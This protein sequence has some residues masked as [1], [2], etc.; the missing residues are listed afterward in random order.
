LSKTDVTF[1]VEEITPYRVYAG[2]EN[3]GNAVAGESR[4]FG[5]VNLGNLFNLDQQLN[6]QFTSAKDPQKWI[7][8]SGTYIIPFRWHHYLKVLGSYS[9]VEPEVEALQNLKGKSYYIGARYEIQLMPYKKLSHDFIFGYDFKTTNNFLTYTDN[10]IFNNNIDISQFLIKYL[11]I[12]EDFLGSTS[13]EAYCYLSPGH[14]TKDNKKSSFSLERK[15]A[16]PTYA[17]FVLDIE[18]LTRFPYKFLLVTNFLSQISTDK[19][20]LSEQLSLGG[21]LTVRGYMENELAGDKGILF[22]NELRLPAIVF[23]RNR[24]ENEIQLLGF[25]DYGIASEI[26]KSILDK[27]TKSILSIGP[28]VR[29]R[30]GSNFTFKLDLGYQLDK[31]KNR[32][33]GKNNTPRV[34]ININ[35]AF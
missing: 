4:F 5:G 31:V 11:A 30:V 25:V 23:G 13:L 29:Y 18:R 6:F 33:D 15:G 10:L 16:K 7:S 3:T 19:L 28:G 8:V 2:Y 1:H 26:D 17:Y 21:A 35:G 9:R 14:M 27:N 22:K 20:L 12:L 24:L 32:V 34:H